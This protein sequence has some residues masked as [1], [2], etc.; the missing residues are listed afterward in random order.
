MGTQEDNAQ[1]LAQLTALGTPGNTFED[2]LANSER[3]LRLLAGL[4]AFDPGQTGFRT[5]DVYAAAQ[6]LC[7]IAEPLLNHLLEKF[8]SNERIKN[9]EPASKLLALLRAG[10]LVDR[11]SLNRVIATFYDD[12][13]YAAHWRRDLY[14]IPQG[15]VTVMS[16]VFGGLQKLRDLL[17]EQTGLA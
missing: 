17:D 8:Q 6:G 2:F 12:W 14:R 5:Q 9:R 15:G 4:Q 11:K 7:R 10:A 16:L 3:G 13:P 1:I